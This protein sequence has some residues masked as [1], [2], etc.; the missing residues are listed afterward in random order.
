[1]RPLASF[2]I[3]GFGSFN[4]RAEWEGLPCFNTHAHGHGT[5]YK[6][7]KSAFLT[8]EGGY[9]LLTFKRGADTMTVQ[10]KNQKGEALDTR[11]IKKI[12]R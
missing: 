11:V 7:P 1:V 12:M 4:E 2:S 5:L 9:L 10:I 3:T 6:D 8:P